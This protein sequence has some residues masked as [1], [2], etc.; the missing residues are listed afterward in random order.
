MSLNI[1]KI[2]QNV[3]NGYDTYDSAVVIAHGE[4][5]ARSMNPAASYGNHVEF[6]DKDDND[7]DSNEYDYANRRSAIMYWSLFKDVQCEL[8]GKAV[9]DSEVSFVCI[10]YVAS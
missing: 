2:W 1:Y 10:K 7:Y 9:K 4:E 5:E 6:L 8:I 3:N